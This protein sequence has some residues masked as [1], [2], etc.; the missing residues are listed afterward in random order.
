[1]AVRGFLTGEC[2]GS[3]SLVIRYFLPVECHYGYD[4]QALV[5]PFL[6]AESNHSQ[7]LVVLSL[8]CRYLNEVDQDDC[9]G[10]DYYDLTLGWL[11]QALVL[12]NA[13]DPRLHRLQ[14]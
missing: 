10:G 5:R 11:Q 1:M 3:Q 2:H 7:A 4:Y 13:V 8:C 14:Q 9:L 6:T 12:Q